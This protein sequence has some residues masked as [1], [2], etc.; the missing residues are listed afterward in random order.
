MK[1]FL[2][3]YLTK[4]DLI[5]VTNLGFYASVFSERIFS[6]FSLTSAAFCMLFDIIDEFRGDLEIGDLLFLERLLGFTFPKLLYASS[7]S[8]LIYLPFSILSIILVKPFGACIEV[9][10]SSLIGVIDL[11][12]ITDRSGVKLLF[13]SGLKV[14]YFCS[15]SLI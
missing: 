12:E 11:E 10:Y 13:I 14:H 8:F 2:G 7:F 6:A 1:V 3:Y 15:Y 9:D 4:G 5:C